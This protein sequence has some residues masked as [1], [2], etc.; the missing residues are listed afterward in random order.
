MMGRG[1]PSMAA[2][3]NTKAAK[4]GRRRRQTRQPRMAADETRRAA[5]HGR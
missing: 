2:D 4:N 3:E 1:Q 5:K